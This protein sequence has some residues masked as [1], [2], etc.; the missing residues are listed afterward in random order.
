MKGNIMGDKSKIEWTATVNPD[1]TVT[2]GATWNPVTGCTK[3]SQGCKHCYAETLANRMWATQYA[4]NLNGM[5]RRFTDVLLHPDR[6]ELPLRWRRPRRIFVNSMSDLFHEYIPDTFIAE[7]FAV[8]AQA[9]QH[10]FQVLTK[11]PQRMA[12]LLNDPAW[13]KRVDE[14]MGL[15]AAEKGWCVDEVEAWPLQN[16]WLGVSVEDQAAADL[17]IPPLLETPAAIRFL[18]CEPLLGPIDL[19]LAIRVD[20]GGFSYN[21][22]TGEHWP[23]TDHP[24]FGSKINWVI[25]GGESGAGARPMCIQWARDLRDQCAQANTPFFFKQWGEWAPAFELDHAPDL[26]VRILTT[27]V[28]G[29]HWTQDARLIGGE[30]STY[31]VGKKQAGRTLDGRTWDEYPAVAA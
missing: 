6:L 9:K 16:V 29:Y 13:M 21:T 30:A 15:R 3:V 22:L 5:P 24:V 14:F 28:T 17:R 2:P 26:Q 25:V 19:E 7:C 1:G 18:S 20:N 27:S 11:R 10:T 8:M 12:Q 23:F 4:A 31:R